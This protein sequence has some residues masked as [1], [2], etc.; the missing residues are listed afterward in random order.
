MTMPKYKPKKSVQSELIEREEVSKAYQ[1]NNEMEDTESDHGQEQTI[2]VGLGLILKEL[3][4]FRKDSSQQLK[5]IREEI[6][7]T[8]TRIEEAEK[9]LTWPKLRYKGRKKQLWSC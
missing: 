5:E 2:E 6:N 8:N 7:K 3:K 4:E 1:A 9:R